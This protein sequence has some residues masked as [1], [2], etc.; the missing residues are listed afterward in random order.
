M[1]LLVPLALSGGCTTGVEV[2]DPAAGDGDPDVAWSD[3]SAVQFPDAEPESSWPDP[4]YTEVIYVDAPDV[5]DDGMGDV[6]IVVVRTRIPGRSQDAALLAYRDGDGPWQPLAS[7]QPGTYRF[8]VTDEAGRYGVAVVH[9]QEGASLPPGA[10]FASVRLYLLT[11]ADTQALDVL[12]PGPWPP[13]DAAKLKVQ[14]DIQGYGQPLDPPSITVAVGNSTDA[15]K[16]PSGTLI[17]QWGVTVP[18]GTYDVACMKGSRGFVLRDVSVKADMPSTDIDFAG[19][20]F[21]L[22]PFQATVEGPASGDLVSARVDYMTAGRSLVP[23]PVSTEAA[24]GFHAPAGAALAPGDQLRIAGQATS[25]DGSRVRL[26]H[27]FFRTP[28][29]R[30]L[31]L[32]A[33]TQK[34]E[35]TASSS[36]PSSPSPRLLLDATWTDVPSTIAFTAAVEKTGSSG[37]WSFTRW[38]TLASK[39]FLGSART[40]AQPDFHGLAGWDDAWDFAAG[41]KPSWELGAW[42]CAKGMDD[43][44]QSMTWG[45]LAV[46]VGV[47]DG[48]VVTAS[49]AKGNL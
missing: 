21:D 20:G 37:Q 39:S 6:P 46:D 33:T 19:S 40:L 9:T 49:F 4:I 25:S 5:L 2:G 3:E 27:L 22:S 18:A 24:F 36:S 14:G 16:K 47:A 34:G 32:P 26:G 38:Y 12:G 11:L 42:Q 30:T 13:G 41:A 7:E 1:A 29:D 45:P 35:V 17:A 31:K 48:L 10:A 8:H 43:L 28:S 44:L 15:V 23:G